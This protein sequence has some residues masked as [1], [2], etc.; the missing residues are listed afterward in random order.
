MARDPQRYLVIQGDDRMKL[1]SP[2]D[3]KFFQ[4]LLDEEDLDDLMDAEE[5]LVPRGFNVAPSSGT[6]SWPRLNSPRRANMAPQE[7]L[8][9]ACHVFFWGVTFF[10]KVMVLNLL[11]R[12]IAVHGP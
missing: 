10:F 5:Y 6:K 2:N 11:V 7:A 9:F 3:S 1:P 8:C 12:L 4:S